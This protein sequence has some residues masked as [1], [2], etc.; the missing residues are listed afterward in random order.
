MVGQA[1]DI[2]IVMSLT[3]EQQ[4]AFLA[5]LEEISEFPK[6]FVLHVEDE[7]PQDSTKFGHISTFGTFVARSVADIS[8]SFVYWTGLH[9][10]DDDKEEH[11]FTRAMRF[12]ESL[13][14]SGN[15]E[16]ISM[17]NYGSDV[18]DDSTV[19]PL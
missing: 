1:P 11:W 15:A 19:T 5:G 12:V 6:Q 10:S 8:D 2:S 9:K 3:I 17:E 13:E 14:A 16:E 4:G 7:S 18:K